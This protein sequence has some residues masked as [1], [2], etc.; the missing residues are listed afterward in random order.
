MTRDRVSD[1]VLCTM[2]VS[3]VMGGLTT[4]WV[5]F[6]KGPWEECFLLT[7]TIPLTTL[8]LSCIYE[9]CTKEDKEDE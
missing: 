4:C 6:F 8:C 5:A 1:I 9:V 2:F 7:V 3:I